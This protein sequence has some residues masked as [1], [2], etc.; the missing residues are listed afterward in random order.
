VQGAHKDKWI[1][2]A[3]AHTKWAASAEG[4]QEK[5]AEAAVHSIK[6]PQVN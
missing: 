4:A 5:G 2:G 6:L 1:Q 3:H